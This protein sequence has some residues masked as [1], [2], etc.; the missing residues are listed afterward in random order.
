MRKFNGKIFGY[1]LVNARGRSK[2]D[3]IQITIA[4]GSA[5]GHS[6]RA[7]FIVG[8]ICGFVPA[9]IDEGLL[10]HQKIILK[11]DHTLR[12]WILWGSQAWS[13]GSVMCDWHSF[14]VK[15]EAE[16]C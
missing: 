15:F 5:A 11:N 3:A 8:P 9:N 2:M 4:T 6:H 13:V 7:S 1:C 16:G 10:H 12:A 14:D